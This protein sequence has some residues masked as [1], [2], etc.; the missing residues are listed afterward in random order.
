MDKRVIENERHFLLDCDLYNTPRR[1]F[2][3]HKNILNP[4]LLTLESFLTLQNNAAHN[5]VLSKTIHNMFK[6]R[7]KFILSLEAEPNSVPN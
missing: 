3:N 6:I 4:N 7:E 1:A 2:L 5:R